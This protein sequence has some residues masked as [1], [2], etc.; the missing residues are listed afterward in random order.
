M[1]TVSD[2]KRFPCTIVLTTGGSMQ[3]GDHLT[4]RSGN[5][6]QGIRPEPTIEQDEAPK[7]PRKRGKRLVTRHANRVVKK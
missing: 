1:R 7:P 6:D 3:R 4:G 5:T 2:R